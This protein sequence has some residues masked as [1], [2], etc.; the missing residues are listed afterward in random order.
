MSD[1]F[2]ISNLTAKIGQVAIEDDSIF[3]F[4]RREKEPTIESVSEPISIKSSRTCV[5]D[6]VSFS[7]NKS[8]DEMDKFLNGFMTKIIEL[9]LTKIATN[10]IFEL[11][12][13]FVEIMHIFNSDSIQMC[14]K[15]DVVN[16]LFGT[17]S[18]VLNKLNE[19]DSQYKCRKIIQTSDSYVKPQK[20]CIGTQLKMKLDK[21]TNLNLP[22]QIRPTFEYIPILRT[23]QNIF[24]KNET[25]SLYFKYNSSLKH[26]C[27]SG[28]YVDFCC[29]KKYKENSLFVNFPESIQLQLFVDAFEVCDGLKPKAGQHSQ[30]GVY[31]AIR[32]MPLELSYNMN[33]IFLIALCNSVWLKDD[34]V[35]YNN[36]WQVIVDDIRLLEDVGIYLN[37]GTQL[38]GDLIDSFDRIFDILNCIQLNIYIQITGTIVNV[39][40]DNLGGNSSLGFVESFM[41]HF[42]CRI[43]TL[44]KEETKHLNCED[45]T[46]LRTRQSYNEII[47]QIQAGQHLDYKETLG[48]KRMCYLNNLKYFHIMDNFNLDIFHDLMEGTVPLLL[49]LFFEHG[50]NHRVFT[51]KELIRAFTYFDYGPLN[52]KCIPSSINMTR[53]NLGQNA[54]QTRCLLLNMPF[55]LYS[56]RHHEMLAQAWN[57]FGSMQKIVRIVYS[58]VIDCSNLQSLKELTSK[59]LAD[60]RDCFGISYTPKLHNMTHMHTSIEMVGPLVHMSTLKFETKHKEFSSDVRRMQN[61]KNVSQSLANNYQMKTMENCFKNEIDFGRKTRFKINDFYRDLFAHFNLTKLFELKSL[62]FNSHYY[63]KALFLK[64]DNFC[65]KIE[66]VLLYESEYY[67]LCIEYT[68]VKFDEF[69][70]SLSISENIPKTYKLLCHSRMSYKKSHSLRQLGKASYIIAESIE[71]KM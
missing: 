31:M 30:I 39:T 34:D 23:L 32:N 43:C 38:R 10:N 45:S 54:S 11:F 63:E 64:N 26:R 28:T 6:Q 19:F 70:N 36:L 50:I 46:K 2:F 25:K 55:V 17:K 71:I 14:P 44:S 57:C 4:V 20:I 51:E 27:T 1:Q 68:C 60:A 47:Q 35:D 40:F 61:Y 53:R 42:F 24:A 5:N 49:K 15:D 67:F 65:Y 41:A 69:L 62:K 13:E 21:K 7:T 33:N 58:P 48:V 29:G 22:T 9:K 18:F 37:D 16:V 8:L 59:H 56:Y 12:S 66:N 52:K 3:N